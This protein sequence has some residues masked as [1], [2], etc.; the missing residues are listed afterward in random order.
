[1]GRN[2]RV[3]GHMHRKG[4]L[5]FIVSLP[6]GGTSLLPATWTNVALPALP[7]DS[8]PDPPGSIGN[9]HDLLNTRVVVD[10]LRS[11]RESALQKPTAQERYHAVG[12]FSDRSGISGNST[13]MEGCHTR[14]TD[15][16]RGHSGSPDGEDR[17]SGND[18]DE[19]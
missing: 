18:G 9:L 11:R 7:P 3:L 14:A 15:D 6:D 13:D 5:H 4:T 2:L 1:M 12:T 8:N 19:Q 10:A 16:T 17:S